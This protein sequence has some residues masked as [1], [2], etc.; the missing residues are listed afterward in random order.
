VRLRIGVLP[1]SVYPRPATAGMES[2]RMP[3]KPG[4][5]GKPSI[6]PLFMRLS[7]ARS[8]SVKSNLAPLQLAMYAFLGTPYPL[9]NI[10]PPPRQL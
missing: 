5:P 2:L 10:F 7:A 6:F 9:M 1:N 3:G 4:A 8:T